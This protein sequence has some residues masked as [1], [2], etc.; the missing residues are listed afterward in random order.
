MKSF[1]LDYSAIVKATTNTASNNKLQAGS[2]FQN[3]CSHFN[4]Y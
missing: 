4:F 1:S 3:R 2:S